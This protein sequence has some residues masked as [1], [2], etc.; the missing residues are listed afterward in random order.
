MSDTPSKNNPTSNAL[1]GAG[2]VLRAYGQA[3]ADSAQILA[4]GQNA[5]FYREQADFARKSGERQQMIFD[6]ESTILY[7][8]QKSAFAKAGVDTSGS[9]LFMAKEMLFR[10][11]ESYAIKQES[12]MNVRLAMLKAS[13][14]DQNAQDIKD[15]Q[16]MQMLSTA[17][18]VAAILI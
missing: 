17:I 13:Q 5:S 2:L 3:Q 9:S 15:S 7:G 14:A 12:D 18:T 4:E 1:L 6:H 11:Q 8:E 10:Q 16:G